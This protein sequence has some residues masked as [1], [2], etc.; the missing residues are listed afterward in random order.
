MTCEQVASLL[1]RYHDGALDGRR[2]AV[3]EAHLQSCPACVTRLAGYRTLDTQIARALTVAPRPG[4]RQSVLEAAEWHGEPAD[5]RVVPWFGTR[6]SQVFHGT[7]AG[8]GVAAFMIMAFALWTSFSSRPEHGQNVAVSLPASTPAVRG[9]SGVHAGALATAAT[10]S[11]PAVP[12][13]SAASTE[14]AQA[15]HADKAGQLHIAREAVLTS[16]AVHGPL[17]SPDSR[18][19]LYLTNWGVHCRDDW[20][21]GTLK[22]WTAQGTRTIAQKV[23]S[24]T[25][26]PDGR[27]IAYTAERPAGKS[28]DEPQDLH[29]ARPDG[30]QDRVLGGADRANVEWL[31]SGIMVVRRGTLVMVDPTSGVASKL[32]HVPSLRVADDSEG[33]VAMSGNERFLA[34]QDITG[35]RIWDR[36]RGGILVLREPLTR[37]AES[38]FHF[39]WDGTA[40]FYSEYDQRY[41]KLYRRLLAPLGPAVAL[42]HDQ[43]LQ[44]PITLVGSPSPDNSIV[45]FRIG[46]GATARNFVIDAV[47]GTAYLL[48]PPAGV[49]PI[50][51]WS[52]DGRSLVYTVYRG[53]DALYTGIARVS[54]R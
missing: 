1:S 43:P 14:Q 12:L 48:L 52:P 19:L 30:L 41:T 4:F 50:G 3:V 16:G 37:F 13:T 23:R 35:L 27:F 15:P 44:G 6:L 17:W 26:S 31:A 53:D 9:S 7:L 18:S 29:V 5:Q 40:V 51:W 25:W 21:C 28:A 20:Y 2:R 32:T 10:H 22:L 34:Y 46:S 24:F 49:G 11:T 42:N 36:A 38:S 54:F 39:S 8:A 45:S 47:Q 33:F